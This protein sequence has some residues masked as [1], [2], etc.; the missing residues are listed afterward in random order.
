MRRNKNT[1]GGGAQTNKNGIA[2]E[3]LT[4]LGNLFNS[5]GYI[6]KNCNEIKSR[7]Q[8]GW[9]VYSDNGEAIGLIV[10]QAGLYRHFLEPNG[11]DWENVISKQLEPD[12]CFFSLKTGAFTIIEKKTQSGA[13]SVD[14]KL[15]TADFKFKTYKK[16]T[17][18]ITTHNGNPIKVKFCYVLDDW[19]KKDCY[20]DV[21]QYIKDVGCDYFFGQVP[22]DYLEIDTDN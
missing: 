12:D 11:V 4:N 10:R 2:F 1:S 6:V 16:L 21:L 9:E 17:S 18:G 20:K 3:N 14:E 5:H 22:I 15:Q 19:F 13:G 8:A 7:V